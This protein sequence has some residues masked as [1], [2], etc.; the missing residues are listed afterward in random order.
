MNL[1]KKQCR[2]VIL[3][4]ILLV[5]VG[6]VG[7]DAPPPGVNHTAKLSGVGD[8]DNDGIPDKKDADDDNDG[9]P[10]KDDTSP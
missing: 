10:D 6:L 8:H 9:T 1:K 3:V 7:C 2:F 4:A 5:C